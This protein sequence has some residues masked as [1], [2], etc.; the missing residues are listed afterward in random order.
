MSDPKKTKSQHAAQRGQTK[1]AILCLRLA[2]DKQTAEA[3]PNFIAFELRAVLV[4]KPTVGLISWLSPPNKNRNDNVPFKKRATSPACAYTCAPWDARNCCAMCSSRHL[5]PG[6]NTARKTPGSS[7]H[8]EIL[9]QGIVSCDCT[10]R[11][12]NCGCMRQPMS[13]LACTPQ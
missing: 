7:T 4:A 10:L 9:E 12:S 5:C 3:C 1:N 11:N 2:L 13:Y 6:S 8:V